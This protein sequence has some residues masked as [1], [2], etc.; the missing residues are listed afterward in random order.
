MLTEQERKKLS[1]IANEL[2]SFIK[3]E[4]PKIIPFTYLDFNQFM[5]KEVRRKEPSFIGEHWKVIGMSQDKILIQHEENDE[6]KL[7]SSMFED[8]VFVDGTP[9][10]KEAI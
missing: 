9:F 7:Y 6:W 1:D 5:L 4:T 8:W 3:L 2:M 10:G